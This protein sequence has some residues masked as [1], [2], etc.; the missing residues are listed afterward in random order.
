MTT[1]GQYGVTAQEGGG[2]PEDYV[3]LIRAYELESIQSCQKYSYTRKP[4]SRVFLA[5]PEGLTK[6]LSSIYHA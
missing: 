4:A 5:P 3:P 6:F 1:R 2:P